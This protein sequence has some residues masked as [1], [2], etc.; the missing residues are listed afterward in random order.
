MADGRVED[1]LSFGPPA[2]TQHS[3]VM[4][5]RA[6]YD[7]MP[8]DAR[9]SDIRVLTEDPLATEVRVEYTLSGHVVSTAILTQRQDDDSYALARTTATIRLLVSGSENLPVRLNGVRIDP[10]LPLA[11]LPGMYVPHT[12]LPLID[13]VDTQ[14]L[15][16]LSLAS[17]ETV[18]FPITAELTTA[19]RTGFLQAAR[20]SLDRCIALREPAP[21]NCPNVVLASEEVVPGSV[22]WTLRDPALVWELVSPALSPHDQSVAVATL[23]M[24]L[25]VEMDLADGQG[26]GS[27]EINLTVPVSATMTGKEAGSISVVWGG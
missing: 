16:I 17:D 4:L 18:E 27:E 13:F 24:Q 8:D 10:S 14:P 5:D 23:S 26:A 11:V 20:T 19:G 25:T 15:D 12:G 7:A 1:A 2:S 6:S 3:T 22:V 9:P 21:T